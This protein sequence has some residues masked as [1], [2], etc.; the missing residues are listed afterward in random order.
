[1][2]IIST[3]YI[4]NGY[5]E[6][7][8]PEDI[9]PCTC[10]GHSISCSGKEI[11]GLK[12]LNQGY[13]ERL[14]IESTSIKIINNNFYGNVVFDKISVFENNN[15]VE[16]EENAFKLGPKEIRIEKN[17]KLNTVSFKKFRED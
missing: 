7:P 13:Y 4:V 5:N 1:L 12:N 2:C 6:C 9:K 16:I 10:S 14:N 17:P 8:N 15:L 11:Q 3:A